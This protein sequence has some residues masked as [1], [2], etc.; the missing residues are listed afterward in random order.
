MDPSRAF[1]SLNNELLLA[2]L[3]AYGFSRNALMLI[4]SYYSQKTKGRN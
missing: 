3:L 4:H 2:K 1:D